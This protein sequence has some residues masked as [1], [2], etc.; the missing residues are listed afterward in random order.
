MT[1]EVQP[2]DTSHRAYHLTHLRMSQKNSDGAVEV[3]PKGGVTI[4]YKVS[5]KIKESGHPA[6]L[7]LYGLAL[8]QKNDR[9]ERDLGRQQA[10]FRVDNYASEDCKL[11]RRLPG[12]FQKDNLG[13]L[14]VV[15]QKIRIL[16]EVEAF[17]DQGFKGSD[18]LSCADLLQKVDEFKIV[19]R[20]VK[21][22]HAEF[23]GAGGF[24]VDL[25]VSLINARNELAQSR[26]IHL[27]LVR[28]ILE[29]A[30]KNGLDDNFLPFSVYWDIEDLLS[31]GLYPVLN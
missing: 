14:E 4:A 24:V 1:I 31:P 22:E 18:L 15:F 19:Q 17:A 26:F 25:P 23:L 11:F 27:S 12:T 21:H 2:D 6:V 3:N 9:Y 16:K 5:E 30:R 7:V 20:D 13:D 10:M 28:L 29:H 8:C